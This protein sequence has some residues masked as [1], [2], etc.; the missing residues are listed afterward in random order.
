MKNRSHWKSRFSVLIRILPLLLLLFPIPL[1]AASESVP[2]AEK[3]TLCLKW[4]HQ[5]QFAGYYAAREKGFYR[6]EGLN[7]HIRER[8]TQSSNIR[9]VL[10]G[11]ARYGVSD[12]VLLLYAIHGEPVV[13]LA[14]VFQQSPLVFMSRMDSG[15]ESPY[16]IKGKR[17]MM[18]PHSTD[19]LPLEAMLF[20]LGIPES[21]YSPVL[22]NL[23]P[24]LLEKGQVDIYPGYLGNEPWYFRKKNIRISII[25][26]KNYGV[27]FYGD[28]LFTSRQ[29]V[30]K[31][32][33]R[34]RKFLRAS[35]KGWTY[36]LEHTEEIIDLILR[37]YST[38]KSREHLR[39]EAEIIRRMIKAEY[40]EMGKCDEGR[41]RYT[42][43]T[44][45]RMGL[46]E[47]E[48]LPEGFLHTPHPV[49]SVSLTDKEKQWIED[50]P[51]I[52]AGNETDWP[53]FDFAED[54]LAKGYSVDLLDLVAKKS[55]LRF[56]YINGYTWDT[57]LQMGKNK[58]LDLLPAIWKTEERE[59][60]FLF[61]SPYIDTPHILVVH[62]NENFI[63]TIEDMKDRTLVGIKGFASTEL[64][65]KYY[66]Q[67]RLAE[68][69]NAVEGLRMVSYRKADAYL[70]SY[71]ETD[72]EIRN[73]LIA[74]LKIAGE[75][76]LGGRIQAS[77]L[78]MAVRK[79]WPE[80]MG[81]IQKSLDA[82]TQQE[83]QKLQEKWIGN[84]IRFRKIELSEMEKNWL[85][86]HPVLRVAFDRDWPPVEFAK[87][88][89]EPD[90]ISADYLKRISDIL[91]VR[92]VAHSPV[93]WKELLA[94]M[95]RG[96]ADFFSAISPT[97][98]RKEWMRFTDTYLSFPIVIVT[99]EKVPYI[100]NLEDLHGHRVAVVNAYAIHDI[101]SEKHPGL[102]LLLTPNV[103]E[104]L[105]AVA[106]GRAFAFIGNLATVSH[107]I[108][109]EG[110]SGLKVSGE[111]PY[112]FNLA[113]GVRKDNTVLHSVLQKALAAI[114][115]YEKNS[116]YSKWIRVSPE[117]VP[118]YSL[119]W[120]TAGGAL[121]IILLTL[122][123]NRRLHRMAH[124]LQNAKEAAETASKAKSVFLANMG[125][126]LRTPLN[127]ILGYAQLLEH[128]SG[129]K[130]MQQEGIRNIRSGGEHLLILIN[131]IL[132]FA[133]MESGKLYL[134]PTEFVFGTFLRQITEIIRA[135][136]NEKGLSLFC[137]FSSDLPHTVYTDEKRLR[138][139]LLH[140]LRNAVKYT[141]E[142]SVIL[143]VQM[144][145]SGSPAAG[146]VLIC[147]AA[148]DTGIGIAP[149]HCET[150]FQPF[151]QAD[152]C[153]IQEGSA[154]LGLAFTRHLVHM[155]GGKLEVHSRPGEGAVFSFTLEM[156][157]RHPEETD[158]LPDISPE[159]LPEEKMQQVLKKVHP[160]QIQMLRQGIDY[161]DPDFLLSA[162][163]EIREY[164]GE[165][166]DLLTRLTENFEYEKISALL[167]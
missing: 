4:R 154:G 145:A 96:D 87:E 35:L 5:F 2:K 75:T 159:D 84:S 89:G 92:I 105:K 103:S 65:K 49:S 102:S 78:H 46:T 161:A 79:D 141:E 153:R 81:I 104:G 137:E 119:V 33:D 10:E 53:P 9:D 27:D 148:E 3:V 18:Y 54:G 20:E 67:I 106:K 88:N 66:P 98:Q 138:Q 26:P 22:K 72:F 69:Q 45:H 99:K 68:V 86:M 149:E 80:L 130:E 85:Q 12:A 108:R 70:G 115:P 134:H 167:P 6:E 57:L 162:I 114:P 25:D 73:H 152:P 94:A 17:V 39:Y 37:R 16:Q 146:S 23:N 120:K 34:P 11:T 129:L 74:N 110:M 7:V 48:E 124:E 122:Y 41:L 117:P 60:Y 59:K 31:H 55:G 144:P 61:S 147:F 133:K 131:D 140:L 1:S 32:P 143:K 14:P 165:T 51:L 42:A 164:D 40:I 77:R 125:H 52:R 91:R 111:T 139:I 19:G 21:D 121:F 163:D 82:V 126:E 142:G 118:D 43:K 155:M 44:L 101:L 56:R 50:H 64:L 151:Q 13:L 93:A 109:R 29:E 71:G 30:Q 166:A 123:W 136:C 47:T 8:E 15:I 127:W 156:L 62:K 128:D 95:Q 150:I 107:I 24:D 132:D 158:S 63:E 83:M 28:M 113:M 157:L 97:D 135:A 116:I 58:E 112:Q 100:G 90:G 36:A 76:T 160:E 38:E